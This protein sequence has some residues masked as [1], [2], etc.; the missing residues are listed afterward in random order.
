MFSLF[1]METLIAAPENFHDNNKLG[2]GGFGV[3][4]KVIQRCERKPFETVFDM[5]C[6]D[7]RLRLAVRF[8]FVSGIVKLQFLK[9]LFLKAL[10]SGEIIVFSQPF[11]EQRR[12]YIIWRDVLT[13][14][15]VNPSIV[16][17]W[18]T[19]KLQDAIRRGKIISD[20]NF[21]AMHDYQ[22]DSR[23]ESQLCP[24]KILVVSL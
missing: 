11:V 18:W 21:K 4:Y 17:K 1:K 20:S 19:E 2:E 23:I 10:G 5:F 8:S 16:L 15:S 3:V 24:H 13:A 6:E 12:I 14:Y 22:K 9:N 7:I